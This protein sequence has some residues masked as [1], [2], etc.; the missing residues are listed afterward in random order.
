M[1]EV[2]DTVRQCGWDTHIY[3]NAS[4]GSLAD[5]SSLMSPQTTG[6]KTA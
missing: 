3:K 2:Q 4:S 5:L 1:Q 6:K